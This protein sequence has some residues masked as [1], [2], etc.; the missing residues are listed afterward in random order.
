M[1]RLKN[2]ITEGKYTR[3]C[4][5][6]I[7]PPGFTSTIID[8]GKQIIP[9]NMLYFDP[10][11]VEDYGR[12]EEPHVTIKFGLTQTYSQEQMG[13]ML[14]G[15]KPFYINIREMDVFQNPKFDV[16]KLNVE[17]EGLHQLRS[18]F[19]QLPNTDEHPVYH[20]HITLAY[21]IPGMGTRFKVKISQKFARIPIN[22]IKYSNPSQVFFYTL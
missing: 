1:I 22:T 8:F 16:V 3:G 10:L 5:M 6:A 19:D 7:I 13:E 4:V 15:I 20:P 18:K 17:G 21:V 12:E 14:K 2:L 9:D 11:G